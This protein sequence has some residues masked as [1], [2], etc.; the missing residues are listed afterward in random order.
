MGWLRKI[1]IL[2]IVVAA[3]LGIRKWVDLKRE[4]AQDIEIVRADLD[5]GDAHLGSWAQKNG[6]AL[7]QLRFKRN[8]SFIYETVGYPANDTVRYSGKH[9]IIATATNMGVYPRLVAVSDNGDTIIH[10]YVYLT[11]AAT[12]NIDILN[13]SKD[14]NIDTAVIQFYRIKQ[15]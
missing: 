4:K 11:R 8:G 7:V 6:N 14:N 3:F 5:E 13:L 10:H 12:K 2:S 15:Q 1:I 9:Q